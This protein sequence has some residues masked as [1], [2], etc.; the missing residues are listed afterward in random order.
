MNIQAFTAAARA[1]ANATGTN[2]QTVPPRQNPAN[3]AQT[4]QT[5]SV[6][7]EAA[8]RPP[9]ARPVIELSD[10]TLTRRDVPRGSLIDIIA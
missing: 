7:R 9:E 5:A 2:P 1:A 8:E 4:A 3:Q 10:S 6:A